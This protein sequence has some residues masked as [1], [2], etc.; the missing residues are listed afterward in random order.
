MFQE[1]LSASQYLVE[2]DFVE[3]TKKLQGGQ[4]IETLEVVKR[5]LLE[6]PSSFNACIEWAR[7]YW[8]EMFH[9]SIAQLL[10]N[11][12]AD[13]TTST[14]Q[15]FWSGPKVLRKLIKLILITC[16]YHSSLLLKPY[17]FSTTF[18]RCPKPLNFDVTCRQHMDF[19]VAAANLKAA[20]YNMP[21]CQDREEIARI[22]KTI[23]P[24]IPNFVPRGM[25]R[26]NFYLV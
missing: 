11:F 17:F 1:P 25:K 14:G 23:E 8:Q 26:Y 4:P 24:T 10:H 21:G 2:A 20:V 9:N 13:Q 19:I 7:R 5:L 15:P 16:L 18:Q 3:K 22:L 12:P 6:R